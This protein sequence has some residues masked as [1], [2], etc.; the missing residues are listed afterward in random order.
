MPKIFQ[1]KVPSVSPDQIRRKV[2]NFRTEIEY[3]KKALTGKAELV[4]LASVERRVVWLEKV[5][6]KHHGKNSN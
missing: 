4:R 1:Q 5:M 3:L 6:E 2:K